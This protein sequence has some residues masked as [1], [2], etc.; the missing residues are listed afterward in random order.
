MSPNKQ[1]REINENRRSLRK[2]VHLVGGDKLILFRELFAI[3]LLIIIRALMLAWITMLGAKHITATALDPRNTDLAVALPAF[4]SV[5]LFRPFPQSKAMHSAQNKDNS[6][7]LLFPAA[8]DMHG[9]LLLLFGVTA[10]AKPIEFRG[11]EVGAAGSRAFGGGTRCTRFK[12]SGKLLWIALRAITLPRLITKEPAV[13]QTGRA[14]L[15]RC[16]GRRR[17][18]GWR[19]YSKLRELLLHSLLDRF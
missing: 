9:S 16:G 3:R 4:A 1:V 18:W 12:R 17:C 13:A 2:L 15:C 10:R 8:F 7:E 11:A 6:T 19:G 14:R 5:L